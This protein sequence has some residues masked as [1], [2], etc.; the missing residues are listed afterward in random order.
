[1]IKYLS[2]DWIE[3]LSAAVAKDSNLKQVAGGINVGITQV[4]TDCPDGTVTYHLQVQD[5]EVSF[6][7]GPAEPEH[8]RFEQSWTTAVGVA[9]GALN[10]QNAFISGQIRLYGDRMLL[11]ESEAIMGALNAVFDQVREQT[12]YNA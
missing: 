8:V 3:A 6:G 1:M 12:D 2:L 4:V 7:A 10:A 9:T 5:G 11:L